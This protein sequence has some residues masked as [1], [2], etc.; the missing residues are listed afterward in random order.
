MKYFRDVDSGIIVRKPDEG[1]HLEY[2]YNDLLKWKQTEPNSKY[3]REYWLGEGN[4][5][6]FDITEKEAISIILSRQDDN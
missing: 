4:M 5:C 1:M 6:L 3:E 2:T